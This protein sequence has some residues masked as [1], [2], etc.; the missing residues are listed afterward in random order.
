MCGAS[1]EDGARLVI[2]HKVP[3]E[4]GGKTQRENLWALCTDCNAGKK[5]HFSSQDA[6]IMKKVMCHKSVHVRLGEFLKASRPHGVPAYAM[7]FVADQADWMKR[8]R[9]LRYLGWAIET[10]R[11]KLPSGKVI[12]QYLLRRSRPWPPDPTAE[13]HRFE[14][15]RALRN[16]ARRS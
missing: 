10:E 5:H 12:A 2:D 14:R 6:D 4:W 8:T 7:E 11:R 16:R 15:R 3:R 1:V 9:E 13:I